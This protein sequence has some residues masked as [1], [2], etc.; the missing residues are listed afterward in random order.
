MLIIPKFSEFKFDDIFNKLKEG[1]K[2]DT[3]IKKVKV[4]GK[5]LLIINSLYYG[6]TKYDKRYIH[7][8]NEIFH[9]IAKRD[10]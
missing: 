1:I 10:P 4:V 6:S 5:I 2:N 7:K 3:I 9:K 8:D